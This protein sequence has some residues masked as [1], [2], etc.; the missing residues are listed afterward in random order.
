MC[1]ISDAPKAPR[2]GDRASGADARSDADVVWLRPRPFPG[3]SVVGGS[4][5]MP[6][7]SSGIVFESQTSVMAGLQQEQ[8]RNKALKALAPLAMHNVSSIMATYLL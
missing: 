6:R 8:G 1:K 3:L 5:G 2:N 4:N 7:G